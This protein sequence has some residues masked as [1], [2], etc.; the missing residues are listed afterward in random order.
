MLRPWEPLRSVRADARE[1]QVWIRADVSA[2]GEKTGCT[3][4]VIKKGQV[5]AGCPGS[6]AFSARVGGAVLPID[7]LAI[8]IASID[9]GMREHRDG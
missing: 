6:Q 7:M 5:V 4:R 1:S 8:E 3:L 9:G 2:S